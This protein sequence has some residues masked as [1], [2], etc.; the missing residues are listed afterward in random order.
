MIN[1][2]ANK[3][4]WRCDVCQEVPP[5]W[6]S[7]TCPKGCGHIVL[8]CGNCASRK[9]VGQQVQE[10]AATCTF[11]LPN[12]DLAGPAPAAPS[13]SKKALFKHG[14][15]AGARLGQI[16]G[17]RVV[18]AGAVLGGALGALAGHVLGHPDVKPLVDFVQDLREPAVEVVKLLRGSR[19]QPPPSPPPEEEKK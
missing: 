16:G 1:T 7:T 15:I 19:K 5:Y 11:S 9:D 14:A 12:F 3:T 8:A 10:H 6:W 4:G 2:I 18:A 13:I 17:P